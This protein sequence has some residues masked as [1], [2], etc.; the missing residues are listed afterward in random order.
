MHM[1]MHAHGHACTYMHAQVELGGLWAPPTAKRCEQIERATKS[2]VPGVGDR[3]AAS[4]WLGF[5]PT[6]S[7]ERCLAQA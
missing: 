5:R 2:M 4:D 7:E 3:V 1:H 6:V